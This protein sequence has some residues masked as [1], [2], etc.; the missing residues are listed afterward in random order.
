MLRGLAFGGYGVTADGN[1]RGARDGHRGR[2]QR[3][4]RGQQVEEEEILIPVSVF[5]VLHVE[6]GTMHTT[7]PVE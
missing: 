5:D 6:L 7:D 4:K 1:G 3:S 2:I